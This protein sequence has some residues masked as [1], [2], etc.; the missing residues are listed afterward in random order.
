MRTS[1]Y[2]ISLKAFATVNNLVL[3]RGVG[4][5]ASEYQLAKE[6]NGMVQPLTQYLTPE[7]LA[8]WVD[9]YEFGRKT[10]QITNTPRGRKKRV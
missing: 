6:V 1:D 4:Y 2:L 3:L 7:L 10:S 5:H 8:M 9:G